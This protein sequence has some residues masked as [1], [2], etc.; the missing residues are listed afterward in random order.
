MRGVGTL[1]RS[2]AAA[3]ALAMGL[4]TAVPVAQGDGAIQERLERYVRP[5]AATGLFSGVVAIARGDTILA[6]T[7]VGR[8]DRSSGSTPTL[9]TPFPLGSLS[10]VFTA[11]LVVKLQ[12]DG[13]LSFDHTLSRYVPGIPNGDRITIEHL[14]RHS[15]GVGAIQSSVPYLRPLAL[16]DLLTF[17][18]RAPARFPPGSREQDGNEAYVL[19]A[20]VIERASGVSYSEYLDRVFLAPLSL[21]G[22]TPLAAA[23][24]PDGAQ[25]NKA[26]LDGAAVPIEQSEAPMVGASGLMS[27]AADLL[28]WTGAVRGT[29]IVNLPALPSPYGW[30]RRSY[31]GHALS[32][33]SGGAEGF[34][35]YIG[36]YDDGHV[37][38]VLSNVQSGMRSR[39]GRDL[40]AVI[41]DGATSSPPRLP[42][43]RVRQ[44][45]GDL[46]GTYTSA[47]GNT[48]TVGRRSGGLWM[49]AGRVPFRQP[50]AHVDR[51][52]FFSASDF[53]LYAFVRNGAG[54][55]TAMR[56][57][58]FEGDAASA[59]SFE[60]R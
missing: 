14:L 33:H 16:D 39:W 32:E 1:W 6:S 5:Y 37:V 44:S 42:V 60:R 26:V 27:T 43:A 38:V 4:G 21:A 40:A 58:P 46:A 56:V 41:Y 31:L 7:A 59:V 53:G 18:G 50:L 22:T 48:L 20:K 34:G 17:I 10:S 11:A 30:E 54:R 45:F 55:V 15:S 36:S 29:D 47:D 9:T 3:L 13:R 57:G 12:Q 28:A 19:L 8:R 51:D 24:V 25:G 2:G 52:L 35:A 23:P 49:T